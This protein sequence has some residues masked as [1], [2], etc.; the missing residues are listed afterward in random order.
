MYGFGGHW[1]EDHGF[2]LPSHNSFKTSILLYKFFSNLSSDYIFIQ[3]KTRVEHEP[4][5][6]EN[7]S[8]R[9][10]LA[11]SEPSR[12]LARAKVKKLEPAHELCL[13][14]TEPGRAEPSR[15]QNVQNNEKNKKKFN[16]FS[17]SLIYIIVFFWIRLCFSYH[18]EF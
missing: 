5:R 2:H 4:A 17:F 11:N 7:F 3:T 6:A 18:V 8:A 15:A 9:A 16:I 13:S 1:S 10:G 14:Q 12:V